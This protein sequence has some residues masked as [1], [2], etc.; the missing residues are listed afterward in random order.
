[1]SRRTE[2]TIARAVY[3]FIQA[4]CTL[5]R[6]EVNTLEIALALR[7]KVNDVNRAVKRLKSKGVRIMKTSGTGATSA[8]RRVRPIEETMP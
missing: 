7:L 1:V 5:G 4:I 2:D 8:K 3:A 6:T